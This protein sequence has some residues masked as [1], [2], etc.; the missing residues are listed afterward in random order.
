MLAHEELTL[1]VKEFKGKLPEPKKQMPTIEMMAL[2]ELG[3]VGRIHH[4]YGLCSILEINLDGRIFH[5]AWHKIWGT[6]NHGY[7]LL[8]KTKED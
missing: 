3:L 1:K 8:T 5:Y 6:K 2:D 4:P 7:L